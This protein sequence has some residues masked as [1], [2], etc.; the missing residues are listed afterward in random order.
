MSKEDWQKWKS[1]AWATTKHEA[2]HYWVGTKL[3]WFDVKISSR[4]AMKAARGKELSRR[5]RQQLARTT[6]DL[7]RLVPMVVILVIPFLEFSLPFLLR[8]FP[9]MLPSTYE[10]KLKK[11]EELKRMLSVKL[12][13]A[14]FLQDTVAEVAKDISRRKGSGSAKELTEFIKKVRSGE[15]VENADILR[16]A[17]LFN[18]ELTLDNLERVQL[19]SMC[20]FVGIAPFG[21]D[22]FL[23]SRLRA[24]LQQIKQ[25]DYAIEQEGLENLTDEELRVACRARGM[26][27]PFGE[28]AV[29]YMRRQLHDWLDL[30]LHRGLPSSLLLL[31]RAFTITATVRD[32]ARKKDL[33]YEKVKETLSVIPEEVVDK[34]SYEAL[35]GENGDT[36]ALEKKLEVLKREEALI[37][38]ELARA[39]KTK[40]T[41]SASA[42]KAAT[43]QAPSDAG[44]DLATSG[45]KLRDA[46]AATETTDEASVDP[47][48]EEEKAQASAEEK[49]RRLNSALQALMDLA[50]GGG[51]AK[52]RTTFM[53]LIKNETDRIN[54]DL[55]MRAKAVGRNLVFS[56]RGMEVTNG[57]DGDSATPSPGATAP[58][59]DSAPN[60]LANR[61]SK[62]LA[63][64]EKEL[65]KVEQSIGGRMR[66][67]DTDNDGVI[68]Q[69]ELLDAVRFLKEQLTPEELQQLVD[70][71]SAKGEGTPGSILVS[72][73]LSLAAKEQKLAAREQR[74]EA[75]RSDGGHKDVVEI[76]IK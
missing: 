76:H 26:R 61:V 74:K 68:S 55:A 70:L 35:G 24:Q 62:M 7:F 5:E 34:V 6:A 20:Q 33:A 12:E 47:I 45:Q 54:S 37:R 38:E 29:A 73:L 56:N 30:S 2:H 52:E 1:G 48:S 15:A 75:G 46:G 60:F 49:Q 27:A 16:F 72:N 19:V 63:N 36:S 58:K 71:L 64:I 66:I 59:E 57:L 14:R 50:S 65:D 51:V 9:N 32:V 25:D 53:E 42:G 40:K 39:E 8:I 13:L 69:Q 21:T 31:S 4:L 22:G 43:A 11:E 10:D 44:L 3:L 67:L 18:D 23:R 41:A 17:Q 28:G